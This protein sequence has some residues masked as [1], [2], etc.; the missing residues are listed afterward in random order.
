MPID[1]EDGKCGMPMRGVLEDGTKLRC[2]FDFA[3]G[4]PCSWAKIPVVEIGGGLTLEEV[5]KRAAAGGIAA[6]A[7]LA[8]VKKR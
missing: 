4:G 7:I 5:E 6:Q 1:N 2:T 8:T 3:H